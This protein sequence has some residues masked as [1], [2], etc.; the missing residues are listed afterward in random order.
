LQEPA[1]AVTGVSPD[2][3]WLEVWSSILATGR[4]PFSSFEIFE[5][6]EES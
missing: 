4:R 3:K 5:A 6:T 1:F 2:G